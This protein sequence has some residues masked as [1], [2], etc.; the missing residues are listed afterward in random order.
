MAL[1]N[2]F[3]V[4][5]VP[6]H[7]TND[8]VVTIPGDATTIQELFERA[9]RGESLG[10][11][12]DEFEEDSIFDDIHDPDMQDELLRESVRMEQV[13]SVKDGVDRVSRSRKSKSKKSETDSESAPSDR[14]GDAGSSSPE[15]SDETGSDAQG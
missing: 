15:L 8:E 10:G 6:E 4:V 2:I 11:S 13:Q 7:S 9:A 1:R 5:E 3:S 12:Y 14:K